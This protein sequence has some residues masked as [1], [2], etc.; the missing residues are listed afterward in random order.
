MKRIQWLSL[1]CMSFLFTACLDTVEE[2]TIQPD[3]SGKV[4]VKMDMGSMLE[5]AKG[6]ME[7]QDLSGMEKERA[8]DTVIMM[9]T[10]T[11]TAKNLSPEKKAL[12]KNAALHMQMNMQKNVFKLDM[13]YPFKNLQQLNDLQSAMKDGG[14]GWMDALKAMPGE[15]L[16]APAQDLQGME[17]MA[18]PGNIYDITVTQNQYK[19]VINKEK[20][21][22]L[23][24]NPK[25]DEFKG[26]MAIM[27]DMNATTIIHFPKPV[28]SV[29]N[30][31]ATISDDKKTVTLKYAI[32]DIFENAEK[33]A[34]TV[35]Y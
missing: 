32:F 23:L 16:D 5:M 27:G 30:P 18:S 26:M 2:L 11:D 24:N 22:Q 6:M 25:M 35:T 21:N 17:N 20:L 12:F 28:K 1:L 7:E 3:G 15:N 13:N 29:S 14:G 8:I 31:A 33:A 9:S 10:I 34:L 4:E 19:K